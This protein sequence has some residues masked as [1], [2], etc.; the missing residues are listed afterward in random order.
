MDIL[1]LLV[2]LKLAR[3][4]QLGQKLVYRDDLQREVGLDECTFEA[5]LERLLAENM[6]GETDGKS[7]VTLLYWGREEAAMTA[8]P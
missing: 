6:I 2:L 7:I 1:Q 3:R 8:Q 4:E 5:V